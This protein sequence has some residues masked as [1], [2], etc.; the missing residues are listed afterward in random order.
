M[1]VSACL[2]LNNLTKSTSIYINKKGA[3]MTRT[4]LSPYVLDYLTASLRAFPG[5]N[6]G[7]LLAGI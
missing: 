3:H 6:A 4:L 1:G 2:V 5:L 7:T